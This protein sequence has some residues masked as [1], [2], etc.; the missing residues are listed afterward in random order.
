MILKDN[1][2]IRNIYIDGTK[3]VNITNIES[4]IIGTDKYAQ[5]LPDNEYVRLIKSN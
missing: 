4:I 5:L 2:Y 3:N 1:I